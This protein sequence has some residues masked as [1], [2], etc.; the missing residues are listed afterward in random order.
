MVIL[1][2]TSVRFGERV[3]EGVALV[4]ID[5]MPEREIVEWSDLGPH[6]VLADVP[7]QRVNARVVQALTRGTID[8]PTPGDM[9][10]LELITRGAGDD[11]SRVKVSAGAVVTRVTHA[12][13]GG[14]GTGGGGRG[15]DAGVT[16]TIELVLVSND[17]A[18]DP[19]VIG[20][21]GNEV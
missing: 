21:A 6:A 1:N 2:P 10:S 13:R 15:G 5:R 12:I 17:G 11:N 3:L 9:A 4:A 8:G 16:R 14:G 18:A 20:A 7:E 19:V